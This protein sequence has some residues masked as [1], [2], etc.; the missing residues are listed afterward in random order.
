MVTREMSPPHLDGILSTYRMIGL[1][2]DTCLAAL[3]PLLDH[4]QTTVGTRVD[5]THVGRA[6]AGDEVTVTVR[7][8]TVRHRRLLTFDIRVEAPSGVIGTGTHQR[9]VVQRSSVA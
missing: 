3:Q 6:R 4:D 8:T 1:M 9:L 2:E 7:L 5:V